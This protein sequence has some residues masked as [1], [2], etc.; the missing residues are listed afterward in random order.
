MSGA[1]RVAYVEDDLEMGR[2]VKFGL[3]V[4][5]T[6]DVTVYRDATTALSGLTSAPAIL[7]VDI[8][9]PDLDGIELCRRLRQRFPALPILA[10]TAYAS[11][12]ERALAAG[13]SDFLAKPVV[14]RDLRTRLRVLARL[15]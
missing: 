1:P 12:R 5:R 14:I 8:G 15:P 13:A 11:E 2:F 7:I 4:A 6:Y 9:L 3:E 10:L